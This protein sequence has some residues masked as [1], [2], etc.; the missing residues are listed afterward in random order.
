MMMFISKPSVVF[1]LTA[2]EAQVL[3]EA[4]LEI[5]NNRESQPEVVAELRYFL[6][7][8]LQKLTPK[9]IAKNKAF[10]FKLLPTQASYLT[11]YLNDFRENNPQNLKGLFL[12]LVNQLNDQYHQYK[13]L[14]QIQTKQLQALGN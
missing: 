1:K 3:S 12:V 8:R 9:N 2:N 11:D 7:A 4:L 5:A 10:S 14:W 6:L 13:V